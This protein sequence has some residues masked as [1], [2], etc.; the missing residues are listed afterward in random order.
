MSRILVVGATGVIGSRL[1]PRLVAAGH[2]VHGTTRRD[3]RLRTIEAQG[4]ASH[5]L[6]VLAAP[7]VERLVEELSPEC[8][9]HVFTDLATLDFAANAQL[10]IDG[11]RILVDAC[12]AAGVPTMLAQSVAWASELGDGDADETTPADPESYPAVASL[13]RDVARMPHGVV[14]RLGLLYGPGTLYAPDGSAADAARRGEIRPTTVHTDWLHVDDAAD[15]FV[16][17]LGWPTGPVFITDDHPSS[18]EEWAPVFAARVGGRV[19]RIADAPPGRIASRRLAA[20]RGWSP[21]HPDWHDG[22]A[23]AAHPGPAD[24]SGRP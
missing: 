11:T 22:L 23:V 1:V 4:A 7:T 6:D 18:V 3:E 12:L 2:E 13:E 24:V 16:A 17:A 21:Q 9:V 14:L 15:A 5:R 8:V 19:D 20:D 10:R